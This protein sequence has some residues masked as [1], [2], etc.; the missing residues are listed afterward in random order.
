LSKIDNINLKNVWYQQDGA[1]CHTTR[2]TIELLK[3]KF[4]VVYVI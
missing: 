1:N 3:Q 2:N 4:N